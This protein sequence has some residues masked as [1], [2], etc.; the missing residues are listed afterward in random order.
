MKFV[1]T[2]LEPGEKRRSRGLKQFLILLS[3]SLTSLVGLFSL[4]CCF[5]VSFEVVTLWGGWFLACCKSR[6]KLMV[7]ERVIEAYHK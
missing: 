3:H 5:S 6:S 7:C 4:A 1:T 2:T